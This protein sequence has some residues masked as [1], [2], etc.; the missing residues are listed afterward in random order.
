MTA[1]T[2]RATHAL[3]G[4]QQRDDRTRLWDPFAGDAS[5]PHRV[6]TDATARERPAIVDGRYRVCRL[7]GSGGMGAVW[8]ARDEVLQR[9]VALKQFTNGEGHDGWSALREARA[10]AR[11]SHPGVVRVHDVLLGTDGDWLVME[12]LPGTPLSAVIRDRGRLPVDEVRK[13][14]LQLLS[15]LHAIHAVGLVHRDIKPSNV[16]VCAPDRVV[17]T[18]FGLTA[19]SGAGRDGEVAGSLRYMAPETITDG[20]YGPPS[21]LY[22]LGVTLYTAVEGRPPFDTDPQLPLPDSV[23]SAALVP[24]AYAGQLGELLNGLLEQD[25]AR[26]MELGAAFEYLRGIGG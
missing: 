16:Q 20:R 4:D 6:A 11:I 19:P 10:A 22:A 5:S 25:S 3:G 15:A 21:D 18:D 8:L 14:G 17:L 2:D 9:V 1:T 7:L 12:A 13:I 23:P 26:R 24:P